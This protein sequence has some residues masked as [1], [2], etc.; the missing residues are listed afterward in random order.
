LL[1]AE[2]I[3]KKTGEKIENTEAPIAKN[4][5]WQ[6]FKGLERNK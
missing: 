6:E 4:I 1:K 3:D 5:S 2:K